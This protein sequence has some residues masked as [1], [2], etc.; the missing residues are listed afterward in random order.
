VTE[1]E[2][3]LFEVSAVLAAEF[4]AGAAQVVGAEPLDPDSFCR[5]LDYAPHCPV[6]QFLSHDAP[7]FGD[8]PEQPSGTVA[9]GSRPGVNKNLDPGV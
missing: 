9:G 5:L 7:T 6:A 1:Q 8:R 4:R 3:D 2:L